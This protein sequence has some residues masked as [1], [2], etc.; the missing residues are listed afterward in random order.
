[1]QIL[2]IRP[3]PSGTGRTLA[4]FDVAITDD[5]RIYGLKLVSTSNGRRVVHPP[6]SYGERVVSLSA[7]LYADIQRAV[8]A[9]LFDREAADAVA[10]ISD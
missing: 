6:K 3:V 8:G 2:E 9:A 7:S 4:H 5:C 10:K 1:M